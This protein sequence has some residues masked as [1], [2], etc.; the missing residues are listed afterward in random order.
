MLASIFVR[1]WCQHA[2]IF[3]SKIHQKPCKNRFQDA[4]LFRSIFA[5]IFLRISFDFGS[6]LGAM[7]TTFSLKT[8][9]ARTSR[10]WFVLGL[11]F[12]CG[13]LGV[14]APS[15]RPLGSI[16]EGSG[17]HFGAFWCPFSSEFPNFLAP[18]FSATLLSPMLK[19]FLH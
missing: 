10:G 6:Q 15:W 5:S 8:W 7:L 13:F 19:H 1:F 17:L 18:A 12:F 11:S 3:P 14:L 9:Q 2:S 16:W 4:S